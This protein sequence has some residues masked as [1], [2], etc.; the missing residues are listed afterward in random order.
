[1]PKDTQKS[2]CNTSLSGRE[3]CLRSIISDKEGRIY[4]ARRGSG[5]NKLGRTFEYQEKRGGIF[6]T[7]VIPASLASLC[8]ILDI[9]VDLDGNVYLAACNIFLKRPKDRSFELVFEKER[10]KY[11]AFFGHIS[12]G[13]AG[14][15]WATSF[16]GDI[17]ELVDGQLKRKFRANNRFKAQDIDISVTGV[18]YVTSKTQKPSGADEQYDPILIVSNKK[19][20]SCELG[21][22]NVANQSVDPIVTFKGR[23]QFVAVSKD[24]TPWTACA[25][26]NDR[27]VY[28]GR[29]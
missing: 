16:A 2:P 19:N 23:A 11:K 3:K 17:F 24:G 13:P 10:K 5:N 26:S 27:H 25:P 15:L 9:T 21:K 22:W 14:T 12:A 18:V 1:M 20:L 29:N 28:R 7:I 6:K 4:G 8:G